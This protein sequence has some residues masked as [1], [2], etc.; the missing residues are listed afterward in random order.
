MQTGSSAGLDGMRPIFLKQLTSKKLDEDRQRLLSA[1]TRLVN[2]IH[3]DK[4]PEAAKGAKL[5]ASEGTFQ[6]PVAEFN[7]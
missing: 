5:G 2:L 4:V 6:K 1:F 3:K 7:P